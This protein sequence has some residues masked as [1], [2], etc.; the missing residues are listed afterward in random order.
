[1]EV[2]GQLHA[3]CFNFREHNCHTLD[4]LLSTFAGAICRWGEG[5]FTQIQDDHFPPEL[6]TGKSVCGRRVTL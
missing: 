4:C 5:I 3:V 2:K 1:M 6:A